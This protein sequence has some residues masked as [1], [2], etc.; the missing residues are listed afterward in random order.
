MRPASRGACLLCLTA[1]LALAGC[2][3]HE[4]HL[5]DG[6]L[7][8]FA[9][10]DP[11]PASFY[12]CHGFGCVIVSHIALSEPEWREVR[13]IF[14]PPPADAV[15]ERHRIAD[16]LALIERQV[17]I[18]TGTSAHQWSRHGGH[19]DGN[20]KIDPTQLDCIDEAVDSWTYLTMLAR[21]GLLRF[22]TVEAL[23]Y[24]GG[25]PDLDAAPRNTA[26]IRATA[27]GVDFAV[28]PMLV[29]AG[30]QPPIIPLSIWTT[31]WPPQIPPNSEP[32]AQ[33][34]N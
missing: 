30:E 31:S 16:A 22:H 20:P 33:N 25:L 34:L 28:D 15:A 11:T 9:V 14:T 6:F 10:K 7:Q 12:E 4:E 2:A 1:L 5:S 21:D 17:G 13:A 18:R 32:T 27:S 19:I 3:A 29:D 8:R 24:A 26:V 23:A